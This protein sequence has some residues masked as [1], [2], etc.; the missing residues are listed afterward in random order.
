MVAQLGLEPRKP[1]GGGF[2]VRSN[3]RYATTPCGELDGTRTRN[4]FLEGE[5]PYSDLA[6]SPDIKNS[7][8]R[9]CYDNKEEALVKS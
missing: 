3:C 5:V 6:N 1:E 2:T 8:F 7:P 4:L 9:A